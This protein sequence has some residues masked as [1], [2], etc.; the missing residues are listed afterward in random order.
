M[1]F[2]VLPPFLQKSG[3]QKLLKVKVMP[4]SF[5]IL[6]L[7]KVLLVLSIKAWAVK[8]RIVDSVSEN[9]STS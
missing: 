2:R 1:F 8:D 5:V 9:V 3:L 6:Q 4:P 7:L